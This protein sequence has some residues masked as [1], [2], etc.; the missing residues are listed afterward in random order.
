MDMLCRHCYQSVPGSA[1]FRQV[2]LPPS[3]NIIVPIT[4]MKKRNK[5]LSYDLAFADRRGFQ[6]LL[7]SNALNLSELDEPE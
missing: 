2:I 5:L 3:I 7:D 4:R 1:V 6:P